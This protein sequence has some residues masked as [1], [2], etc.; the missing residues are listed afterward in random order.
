MPPAPTRSSWRGVGHSSTTTATLSI[1]RPS[2]GGI[3][4]SASATICSKRSARH[5]D[6]PSRDFPLISRVRRLYDA[7]AGEHQSGAGSAQLELRGRPRREGGAASGRRTGRIRCGDRTERDHPREARAAGGHGRDRAP[8]ATRG[9]GSEVV[10][11][12]WPRGDPSCDAAETTR[13]L[14]LFRRRSLAGAPR[15]CTIDCVV[16]GRYRAA[17]DALLQG[18]DATQRDAVTSPRR[19]AGDPRRCGLGQDAR[20]H[21]PHRVAVARAASSIPPTSS[22]SPSPARPRASCGPASPA[23]GVRESV[24]AGTFHAIALAQLRR[25]GRRAGPRDARRCSSARSGSS[26]RCSRRGVGRPRSSP[27]SSRRRSSGPRRA[28]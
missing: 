8:G 6:Q 4:S 21:P 23:S 24:T 11:R 22:P 7:E 26:C 9:E 1:S 18:L 17:V 20:A 12:N 3:S 19:A 10:G 14:L 2:A 28:W 13:G 27:P 15:V 16:P 25:R 5:A